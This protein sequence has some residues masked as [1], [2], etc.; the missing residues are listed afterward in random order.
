M[1]IRATKTWTANN[2]L[3]EARLKRGANGDF[4]DVEGI[5]PLSPVD[6]HIMGYMVVDAREDELEQLEAAGYR[7][8]ARKSMLWEV[9]QSVVRRWRWG[10]K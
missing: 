3:R 4:L 9:V 5:G 2:D 6:F 7:D 1:R 10:E 8:H